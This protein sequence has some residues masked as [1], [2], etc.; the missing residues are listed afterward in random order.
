MELNIDIQGTINQL[1]ELFKTAY[2]DKWPEIE[3]I[4]EDYLNDTEERLLT[5][6]D[7]LLLG[8]ANGGVSLDFAVE[9]LKEEPA[10]LKTELTSF[11]VIAGATAENLTNNVTSIFQNI[12]D[13]IS[14]P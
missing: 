1:R 13:G 8:E 9:R 5:L 6:K 10:I 7:N 12:I 2:N 14:K 4:A 3:S 11:A